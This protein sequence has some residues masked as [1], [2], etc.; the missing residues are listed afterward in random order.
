MQRWARPARMR[1]PSA[2]CSKPASTCSAS[3]SV[4]A[5]RKTTPGATRSSAASSAIWA[6]PIAV[7]QDLQGPKIRIGA[8][9]GGKAMLQN[10]TVVRFD[11]DKQPGD[12]DA[13]APPAPGGVRRHRARAPGADQ[14]RP[15]AARGDRLRADAFRCAR[16]GRRR[17]QRP[18]GRQPARHAAATLPASPPRTAPTW[19]SDCRSASISWRCR[20]CSSPP[21]SSRAQPGRRQSPADGQDR[22][23]GRPQAHQGDRAA[24]RRRDGGARRPRRRDPGR[25]CARLAEGHRARVPHGRQAGDHRH[26][27]AGVDDTVADAHPRGGLRCGHRRLRRRRCRHAVGRSR[28]P[29]PIPSRPWR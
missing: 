9:A 18:Q 28:P 27:D 24:G 16:A 17:G 15:R 21:M 7:L 6:G 2:A 20:S 11:S 8:V 12:A 29:A 19:S 23:A 25:G 4:T 13:P 10:G 26:A 22:E 3:I 14:R 5:A 1:P